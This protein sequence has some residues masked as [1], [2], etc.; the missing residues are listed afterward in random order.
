MEKCP[1]LGKL[2]FEQ[3]KK[4][5]E[6]IALRYRNN[7][8]KKWESVS[9]NQFAEDV[10]LLAK[11]FLDLGIKKQ[12]NVAMF[13][14]NRYELVASDF[15]LQTIH[16]VAVP[17][18]ATSSV[19]QVLYFV[20]DAEIKFL[21]AGDQLQYDVAMEVLKK[22][23][24]L[25][26]IIAVSENID[27]RGNVDAIRYKCLMEKAKNLSNDDDVQECLDT[28]SFDD[29]ATIIYT[30]GTTGVSKGVM[31]T[32]SN[33]DEAMRIHDIRVDCVN[34]QDVSIAFLPLSHIFERAWT[35]FCLHRATRV[36]LNFDPKN[37]Q[38]IVKEVRP[39]AMCSVPRF[40]EKVYTGVQE[41]I[42]TFPKI[43]QKFT[44]WAIKIGGEYNLNYVRNEKKAPLS[45][46]I[47]Y[48]FVDK[49]LFR[50]LKK[51]I[52]I[53]NG[54]L[55]P[56][57]GA[58]LS[59]EVNS[60]LHSV[61]INI[62]MGYGLS[63]TTATVSCFNAYNKKYT[64]G[65][66]GTPM[67]DVHVKIGENNEILVKGKTVTKGYY[68]KE[69]E[70]QEAFDD[71][72]WF[73]TG[74]AGAID[75]KGNLIITERIK[76][77]YKTSNGKY[78]APQQI[79]SKL[80]ADK[81]IEQVAV[82]ADQRKYVSALIV[83]AVDQLKRFAEENDIPFSNEEELVK[84]KTINEMIQE[85]IAALQSSLASFEQIKKFTL[86][87]KPFSAEKG[88]LTTTLKL[89]RKEIAKRY[90]EIID[91]MYPKEGSDKK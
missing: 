31:I 83:P 78:I 88:E 23:N 39:T 41:K 50:T 89:K 24:H 84:N 33:Y 79:E 51:V 73:H 60:F 26:T 46:R 21:I 36:D 4:Y 87:S 58:Y 11:A 43:L 25:K 29:L 68:K 62:C 35:Y 28:L 3:A 57:A 64:I 14:Q 47:K 77:L 66:V 22:S 40:W 69:K 45:L 48:A 53:E 9:W 16:G 52:G 18:Y 38:E 72:G 81:Y 2:V 67:P 19:D 71:E 56:C 37:I 32:H 55:F 10:K 5:G 74:D 6:K 80:G 59:D 44:H 7:E 86:L 12:E 90:Q 82:I 34:E 30:S 42:E 65:T 49:T 75:E 13:S 17:M 54:I 61:G 8:L 1:H 76:D 15:A 63:E 70:T 27:L 91:K 85:R 20:E